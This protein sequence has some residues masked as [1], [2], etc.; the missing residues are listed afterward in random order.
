MTLRTAAPR[1]DPVAVR[2]D[3]KSVITGE[4]VGYRGKL[5]EAIVAVPPP[6]VLEDH[7]GRG[8]PALKI[9]REFLPEC[10]DARIRRVV[11]EMEVVEEA[12]G[13]AEMKAQERVHPAP[14]HV[15]HLHRAC[16]GQRLEITDERG[17]AALLVGY[18][19]RIGRVHALGDEE[20]ERE[21]E[22]GEGEGAGQGGR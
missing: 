20:R 18:P 11:E 5:V 15:H 12:R 16:P 8:S 3:G 9:A 19:R 1:I 17:D 22:P 14:R 7:D 4:K 13:L 6:R 2:L 10:L 21:H